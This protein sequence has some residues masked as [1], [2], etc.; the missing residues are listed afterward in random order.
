MDRRIS[1]FFNITA[2]ISTSHSFINSLKTEACVRP[3]SSYRASFDVPCGEWATIRVPFSQLLGHG[4]GAAET[5]F[6]KSVL[7]RL[8]IV[9]IGKEMRVELALAGI[10]FY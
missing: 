9:A 6:N 4:P 8:G 1:C 7:T 10:R 5:P 2:L 3:F